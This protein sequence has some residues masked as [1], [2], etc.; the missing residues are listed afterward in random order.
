MERASSTDRPPHRPGCHFC[1]LLEHFIGDFQ[2]VLEYIRAGKCK[3][4][5]DNRIVLSTGA[6]IP[7]NIP[8][9]LFKDRIDEWHCRNPNQLAAGQLMLGVISN[10]I[11]E[12]LVSASLNLAT[13][14][15][16]PDL[17]DSSLSLSTQLTAQE[18]INSLEHELFQLRGRRADPPVCTR[19]QRQADEEQ[20]AAP[21]TTHSPTTRLQPVVEIEVRQSKGKQREDPPV[22]STSSSAPSTN[23]LRSHLASQQVNHQSIHSPKSMMQRTHLPATRTLQLHLNQQ[24]RRNLSQPIALWPPSMMTKSRL[25]S[26]TGLWIRKLPSHIAESVNL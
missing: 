16:H 14:H 25:M 3:R 26:M 20:N 7:C 17:L 4:D 5:V 22:Q 6:F 23:H 13:Q 1:G 9:A 19:A 21:K 2:V 15:T 18:R 10:S 8:G 24:T 11:S 12:P